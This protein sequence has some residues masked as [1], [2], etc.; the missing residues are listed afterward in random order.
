MSYDLRHEHRS[1]PGRAT[2]RPYARLPCA[3]APPPSRAPRGPGRSPALLLA[4]PATAGPEARPIVDELLS[5]VRGEQ[6]GIEI[7]AGYLAAE[8]EDAPTVSDLLAMA[9]YNGAPPPI[10]VP[11]LPGPHGFLTELHEVAA[12]AAL[13]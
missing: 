11:L 10:V 7:A 6:P 4:V 12:A 3:G 8:S 2:A 13:R 9:A 1:H 5:I